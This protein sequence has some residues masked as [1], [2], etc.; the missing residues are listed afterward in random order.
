MNQ[1]MYPISTDTSN[2]RIP[3]K[4]LSSSVSVSVSVSVSKNQK[5]QSN[6]TIILC[7]NHQETNND[8]DNNSNKC[9]INK[10]KR[11]ENP[12]L[13][14]KNKHVVSSEY[15][16]TK[17]KTENRNQTITMN[18]K[19]SSSTS[20]SYSNNYEKHK[21]GEQSSSASNRATKILN[22][23]KVSK[24][25]ERSC[26]TISSSGCDTYCSSSAT[27][28]KYSSS[29]NTCSTNINR[30]IHRTNENIT[31]S[32]QASSSSTATATSST[33]TVTPSTSNISK[34]KYNK[35]HNP[36]NNAKNNSSNVQKATKPMMKNPY[37]VM[38]NNNIYNNV[39]TTSTRSTTSQI[40]RE[41]GINNNYV[42]LHEQTNNNRNSNNDISHN[43]YKSYYGEKNKNE[44]KIENN[45]YSSDCRT[46]CLPTNCE[47]KQN[48]TTMPTTTSVSEINYNNNNDSKVRV[49]KSVNT[50]T[51]T[52]QQSA[53]Q[54]S[55]NDVQSKPNTFSNQT[56]S[57]SSTTSS[58]SQNTKNI[59]QQN[60]KNYD[61][62]DTQK[63]V[64]VSQTVNNSHTNQ[65]NNTY[66]NQN[67]SPSLLSSSSSSSCQN[68]V[69]PT[70]KYDYNTTQ[71]VTVTPPQTVNM[72][73]NYTKPPNKNTYSNQN[74]SLSS[75]QNIQNITQHTKGYDYNTNIQV[76][77]PSL[78]ITGTSSNYMSMKPSSTNDFYSNQNTTTSSSSSFKNINSFIKMPLPKELIYDE[79]RLKP[80][81]DEYRME[82]I[83]NADM[84][85]KL[86]NG[87]KL[88]PHQK[89]GIVRSLQ[90]RRMV[91]AYDMGLGKTLIG[92]V[93][94]KA[95]IQTFPDIKVFI[96]TPVSLKEAWKRTAN[97]VTGLV[98]EEEVTTKKKT[99]KQSTSSSDFSVQIF[100][101]AKAPMAA[102]KS[103]KHYVVICDEAH[104]MQNMESS[105]TKDTL[106]LVL[107]EKCKGVLL[108]TGTPMKNGKPTN[109]FP[110]L[111][112]IRH[113]FGDDQKL[114]ETFFCC[115]QTRQYGNRMV[116]DASG[117]SNLTLLNKHIASH[118]LY[119]TKEEC[120]KELP[121]KV[122]EFKQVPVGSRFE[123][124]HTQAML[125]LADI[126]RSLDSL[127]GD[128][129]H[130]AILGS[131]SKVRL[132]SAFSKVDATVALAKSILEKESSIVIFNYFVQVAR[133]IHRKL[134]EFGWTG[135]LLVGE[136]ATKKRQAMV[137]RFQ[138]GVSPV[139]VA[140]FGAGGVGITLTAACTI[141]L[142]DRPWTPGDA[143][144]AEDRVRRI[145][146]LRPV[147]SI[148]LRSFK[149]DEQIDNLLEQKTLNTS[150][151]VNR[152][153][154][155]EAM[156][157][158]KF[159]SAPRISIRKL[160]KSIL[161]KNND[162]VVK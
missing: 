3:S 161:E 141:I 108:L 119:K 107:S 36:Y 90:M 63:V 32:V 97:D 60:R 104:S 113:P 70:K 73:S 153:E 133:D 130:D 55:Q 160:V 23:Y 47:L 92:C 18:T 102:P 82:L 24:K 157:A 6:T 139:F 38:N 78:Q 127:D 154:G 105:R 76:A 93:W 10:R 147:R 69:Q 48:A 62:H 26:D 34:Q 146:Q 126:Q 131:F 61:S 143:L 72:N 101:W 80:V 41:K 109:L 75:S 132:I 111:K 21:R 129:G 56:M 124:Q 128:K 96:I 42:K 106:Q 148:W 54:E 155:K 134:N 30:A 85:S 13:R 103:I 68:I 135:E 100:S 64:Q 151:V 95:F 158:N 14:M 37:H 66:P 1:T 99:K 122:R 112:A 4:P 81:D 22:P 8:N 27:A 49:V 45:V 28:I 114:Y 94:A 123:L 52:K 25:E 117:S 162:D 5:D 7:D 86:K 156:D 159:K 44:Q 91:L 121:K 136:T 58:S 40:E 50:S 118:L 43:M 142:V 115:G 33:V 120:L 74:M 98:C 53:M 31:T 67:I 79:R 116:W 35:I 39:C 59:A 2:E 12:Y 149:V 17:T 150:E 46:T 57:S 145:G 20:S 110:L 138:T 65:L 152:H 29:S 137:D 15:D 71:K 16:G 11:I 83:K 84:N 51:E 88:L 9:I 144:Q 89:A 77:K 125:E 140:T 19:S 87:W